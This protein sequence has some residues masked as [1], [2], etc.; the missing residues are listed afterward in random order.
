MRT[1]FIFV[2]LLALLLLGCG[3]KKANV[4]E[5]GSTG[6]AV[7]AELSQRESGEF[8]SYSHSFTID[9]REDEIRAAYSA[10]VEACAADKEHGCT[11]LDANLSSGRYTSAYIKLRTKPEGVRPILDVAA[12]YGEIIQE[13]THVDDLAQPVVDNKKRLA[14]L[15]NHR[16]RLLVL[17]EKASSDIQALIKISEELSKVQSQLESAAGQEA[18]LK[19]RIAKDIVE[20]HFSSIAGRSFWRP[21]SKALSGFTGKL[22]EGI[23]DTISTAAYLLPW[24]V[25]GMPALFLLRLMWRRGRRM[26]G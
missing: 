26:R 1:Q 25:L 18:H 10:T 3:K 20:I 11:I 2:F 5:P 15:E 19:E 4:H 9:L 13:K 22:A 16:D 24:L 17:H 8:L 21:I 12:G 6:I 14:M 23:S 7:Q